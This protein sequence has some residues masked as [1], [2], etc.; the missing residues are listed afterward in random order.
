MSR[1]K[2]VLNLNLTELDAILAQIA[3]ITGMPIGEMVPS[4]NTLLE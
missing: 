3:E 2:F 4:A 1:M